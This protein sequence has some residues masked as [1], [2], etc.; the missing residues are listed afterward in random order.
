VGTG[1]ILASFF[2]NTAH[3][4]AMTVVVPPRAG[5]GVVVKK[6]TDDHRSQCARTS[7]DAVRVSRT[8]AVE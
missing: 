4:S 6:E 5:G 2:R 7:G 3:T 1:K 8:V